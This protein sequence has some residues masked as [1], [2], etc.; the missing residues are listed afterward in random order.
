MGFSFKPF[1]NFC[2][3]KKIDW[4]AVIFSYIVIF[5][6]ILLKDSLHNNSGQIGIM[7]VYLCQLLNL[8]QWTIRQSCECENLMTSIERILEYT[9]LPS[10]PLDKGAIEPPIDWIKQGRITFDNVSFSYAEN[11]PDILHN[12]S[13][14]IKSNE[15]IGIIGRTGA[16]KSSIIQSLFR[17][18]EPKGKILIDDVDIK[19]ISLHNLR[20]KLSIIPVNI[21][22]FFNKNLNIMISLY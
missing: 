12:L 8:F 6:C 17:M 4:I 10:E 7:L 13:F 21:I 1:F 14:E 16:G 2:F 9:T 15:K 22:L 5:S 18:A 11:L 20:G 3:I 19:Q